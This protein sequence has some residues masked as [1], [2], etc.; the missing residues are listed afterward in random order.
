ML[1]IYSTIFYQT[2]ERGAVFSIFK[3]MKMQKRQNFLIGTMNC[4]LS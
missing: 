3:S 1:V 4:N 2:K